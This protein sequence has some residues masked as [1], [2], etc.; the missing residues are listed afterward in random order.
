VVSVKIRSHPAFC[1]GTQP[2][3]IGN[4]RTPAEAGIR[5]PIPNNAE[6]IVG[7]TTFSNLDGYVR[8]YRPEEDRNWPHKPEDEI[9]FGLHESCVDADIVFWSVCHLSHHADEGEDHWHTV[10][11]NIQLRPMVVA[12]VPPETLRKVLVTGTMAVKDFGVFKITGTTQASQSRYSSTRMS[13]S[14][15][16][17]KSSCKV[18]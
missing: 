6:G 10:G 9:S 8:K 17:S 4:I 18:T 7:P 16:S 2:P 11:P 14:K 15:K 3:D 5:P 13:A 1:R 12:N